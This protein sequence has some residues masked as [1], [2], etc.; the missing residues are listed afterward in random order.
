MKF[1]KPGT[2]YQISGLNVSG[3][4]AR[5]NNSPI[6]IAFSLEEAVRVYREIHPQAGIL[7]I[8]SVGECAGIAENVLSTSIVP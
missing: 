2:L 7:E 1:K 4:G 6:V 3:T 8:K 5:S